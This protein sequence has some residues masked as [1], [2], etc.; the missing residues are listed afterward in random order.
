MAQYRPGR[1]GPDDSDDS[2]SQRFL[3][4]RQCL[5]AIATS[6]PAMSLA[7]PHNFGCGLAG[8]IWQDVLNELCIFARVAQHLQVTI[9]TATD[10]SC[11]NLSRARPPKPGPMGPVSPPLA[12]QFS[13]LSVCSGPAIP[14]GF[15][16]QL[17]T[18][19]PCTQLTRVDVSRPSVSRE[20]VVRLVASGAFDVLVLSP[21]ANADHADFAA[22]I[23]AA[24]LPHCRVAAYYPEDVTVGD[25]AKK[26][27][28][29]YTSTVPWSNVAVSTYYTS[30]LRKLSKGTCLRRG[31]F[32]QCYFNTAS[33][34][35]CS[36]RPTAVLTDL[37]GILAC[38]A[39]KTGWPRFTVP[40][41]ENKELTYAGPLA[42]P[43]GCA[44]GHVLDTESC[45]FAR[46]YL[47]P[48]VSDWFSQEV[49][50]YGLSRLA[51]DSGAPS[52]S[53]PPT[54][55]SRSPGKP[56]PRHGGQGSEPPSPQ[57]NVGDPVVPSVHQKVFDGLRLPFHSEAAQ[58]LTMLRDIE[59]GPQK[60]PH[61]P[62]LGLCLGASNCPRGPYV[63]KMTDAQIALLTAINNVVHRYADTS[64]FKWSSIQINKN[65]VAEKHKD[66]NNEGLSAIAL[67][68]DFTEGE[69]TVHTVPQL[70]FNERNT[71]LFFDGHE[72]HESAKY[73]GTERYSFVIFYHKAAGNL[74]V[75]K[76]KFLTK[77]GF[78]LPDKGA[79]YP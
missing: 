31:A 30:L 18:A 70:I 65:T 5:A 20:Q 28:A 61:V 11:H 14:D 62:G 3:W 54:G 15:E 78:C 1:P 13:V 74:A 71:F 6:T 44:S 53:R 79:A 52:P 48:L 56:A 22:S 38:P 41:T 73:G 45:A 35:T 55:T 24:G 9:V 23:I 49:A 66:S 77:I 69:L 43:C 33:V 59:W 19:L 67:L 32:Y 76:R 10:P 64:T 37:P 29:H 16:Y 58:I 21:P 4:L 17:R 50:N 63:T 60:R 2:V 7:F 8:G 12:S 46:S 40:P 25:P 72:F 39:F 51:R 34:P 68:G 36:G 75:E 57:R 27:S 47:L 26:L 42:L